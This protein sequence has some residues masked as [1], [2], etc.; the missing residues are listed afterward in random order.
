MFAKITN[1]SVGRFPYSVGELLLDNPNTSFPQQPSAATLASYGVFE[2]TNKP[3]PEYNPE[4][5]FVEYGAVPVKEGDS[6]FLLPTVRELSAEQLAARYDAAAASVR[7]QRNSLL[8]QTDW[9][10]LS[11]VTMSP[12]MATYRQ[13]LRD[14]TSQPGF[15]H[16]V[17]WPLKPEA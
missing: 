15:P 8:S 11:D 10:A 3:S 16:S 4:T 17:V 5:H 6:W 12:A 14:I 9:T 2:V 13:A 1:G 7:G